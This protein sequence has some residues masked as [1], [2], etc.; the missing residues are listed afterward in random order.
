MS[1]PGAETSLPWALILAGGDGRRLRSLTRRIA[2]DERPKQFCRVL[3]HDTLLEQT[4]RRSALAIPRDRTMAVVVGAHER[5]YA[6]VLSDFPP[7]RLAIQPENRGTAPA[8]LYGLLRML[9]AAPRSPLVVFPS[10][11][12][13]SND[14]GFMGHVQTAVRAV[15]ARPDLVVLLGV[16]PDSADVADGWIE[17]GERI[18]GPG[19]PEL[20]RAR[21]I[22]EKPSP[23]LAVALRARG[24]LWDSFVMVAYPCAVLN[25]VRS[26][27]PTLIEAFAPVQ[28]HLGTPW[29]SVSLR[30]VYARL[31]SMNFARCVVGTCPANLAVLC[32]DGVE[33]SR[34]ALAHR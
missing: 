28:K 14:A 17:P 11:H 19:R 30:Q 15:V 29:E 31:P 6:P 34:E 27:A 12:Y 22:W 5:F 1:L 16:R 32:L 18:A 4:L 24:C 26:A 3:D 10:D 9:T 33:W 8:I 7:Q 2:G 21:Q 20:H 25:M 13:V 23:R